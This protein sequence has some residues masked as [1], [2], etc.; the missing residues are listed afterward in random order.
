MK[1]YKFILKCLMIIVVI[2]VSQNVYAQ[3]DSVK[4]VKYS[5]G[6]RFRSGLY[7]SHNQLIENS[8]VP[9]KRIVSKFN[10]SGFDFFEKLLS[11]ETV[12]F[13]DEFG[14]KKTVNVDNLWGFCRRGSV[15]INWGDDFNRIPVVGNIC[16]FI[17]SITVYE[18]NY[19]SSYG[20]SFYN[21][22]TT[23]SRTDIYQFLMDFDTGKVIE[24]SVGNVLVLLMADPV[25]FDEYNSLS[26]KKKKQM[27]FLYIRKYNE[28]H[29]LYLP[30]N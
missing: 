19:N 16:H 10:K 27:K 28:K 5:P 26:K 15:Y 8:P 12:I 18:N 9:I 25:L 7:I 13:Y 2:T 29:S 30:I 14:M 6:F 11:E 3:I 21:M 1:L 20:N 17:A 23:T 24:Y 22:P 4:L